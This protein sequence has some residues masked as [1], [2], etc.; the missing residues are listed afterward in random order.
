MKNTKEEKSSQNFHFNSF[1]SVTVAYALIYFIAHQF[2][3]PLKYDLM[4]LVSYILLVA[5]IFR[6]YFKSDNEA[7]K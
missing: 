1:L 5:F 4:L 6:N 2:V 7:S 3:V